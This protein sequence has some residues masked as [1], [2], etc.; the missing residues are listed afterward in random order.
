MSAFAAFP[1]ALPPAIPGR[2]CPVCGHSAPHIDWVEDAGG[3]VLRLAECPRCEHRSTTPVCSG[4]PPATVRP[5]RVVR[6][7]ASAA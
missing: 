3:R 1:W 4:P 2:A 6:E 5:L 7:V